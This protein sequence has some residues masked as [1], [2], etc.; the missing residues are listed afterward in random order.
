MD[1]DGDLTAARELIRVVAPGGTLLYGVP[2][3][4]HARIQ[5]NAPRIYTHE[6]VLA[7]FLEL[8]LVGS[9]LTPDH[10]ATEGLIR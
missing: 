2:V 3:S 5:F 8:E 1:Y 6:Q 4:G 9:A 10:R 7:M